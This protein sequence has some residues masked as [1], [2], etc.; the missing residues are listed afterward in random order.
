MSGLFL[1]F[2]VTACCSWSNYLYL[3]V[4]SF[5]IGLKFLVSYLYILLRYNYIYLFMLH[6][7]LQNILSKRLLISSVECKRFPQR[8]MIH[9]Y[10]LICRC[11]VLQVTCR[12]L[13]YVPPTVLGQTLLSV[14]SVLSSDFRTH[15]L[16]L[17]FGPPHTI[18][19]GKLAFSYIPDGSIG[20]SIDSVVMIKVLDWWGSSYPNAIEEKPTTSEMTGSIPV[21]DF[22]WSKS[23]SNI[24]WPKKNNY[25]IMKIRYCKSFWQDNSLFRRE[26]LYVSRYGFNL[27][28]FVFLY[29][30]KWGL[31]FV[32][33]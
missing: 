30:L 11:K 7:A 1:T 33:R 13:A 14:N 19:Q 6:S 15:C 27:C 29:N 9:L 2:K 20:V 26:L 16:R 3:R 32:L 10:F 8:N 17:I 12:T 4:N 31:Y 21:D 24:N 23:F 5:I 22:F 25:Y 28:M 18:H